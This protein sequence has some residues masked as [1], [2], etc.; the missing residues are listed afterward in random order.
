MGSDSSKPTRNSNEN[1]PSERLYSK[2]C[3]MFLITT[4]SYTEYECLKF[5]D[6]NSKWMPMLVNGSSVYGTSCSRALPYAVEGGHLRVALRLIDYGIDVNATNSIGR[7]ALHIASEKGYL[8]IVKRLLDAG[9]NVDCVD[10]VSEFVSTP[11]MY[12]VEKNHIDIA[13]EL[14]KRGANVNHADKGGDTPLLCLCDKGDSS[15]LSRT[16]NYSRC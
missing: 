13:R 14:I 10:C 15:L 6:E 12:A 2:Y 8:D 3:S 9:V 1:N 7:T 16:S 11:L 5:M 4:G